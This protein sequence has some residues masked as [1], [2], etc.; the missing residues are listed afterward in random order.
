MR[1]TLTLD[2]DVATHLDRL[3]SERGAT[4]KELVNTA[5]RLG[6]AR[7][8]EPPEASSRYETPAVSLGGCFLPD[9][10]DVVEALTFAEGEGFR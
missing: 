3:K 6:L 1:T 4:I 7:L 9:L 8:E 2:E 5:L 10:D